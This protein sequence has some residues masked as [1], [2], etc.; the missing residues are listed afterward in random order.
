MATETR[1]IQPFYWLLGS[2]SFV[3]VIAGLRAAQ[4]LVV[5]FLVA[6]FLAVICT[7]AFHWLKQK[8]V[9]VWLAILIVVLA[10]SVVVVN[11]FMVAQDSITDFINKAEANQQTLRER[12]QSELGRGQHPRFVA[13]PRSRGFTIRLCFRITP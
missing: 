12:V 10:V 11:V 9:P 7:P 6:A 1:T 4:S 8:H 5:P 13:G 2:A 3:V